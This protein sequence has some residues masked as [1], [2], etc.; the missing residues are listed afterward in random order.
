MAPWG[1]QRSLGKP[2]AS[3][4]SGLLG[5]SCV[6]KWKGW[7]RGS[8][9]GITVQ[10]QSCRRGFLQILA[11]ASVREGAAC[12]SLP[13]TYKH[14]TD[15]V[16]DSKPLTELLHWAR[17]VLDWGHPAETLFVY[18]VVV[19]LTLSLGT[20]SPSYTLSS[21]VTCSSPGWLG[22]VGSTSETWRR[23]RRNA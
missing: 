12:I 14:M 15:L 17:R 7:S 19:A 23:R 3:A 11:R 5:S 1:R 4:E 6:I 22:R 10:I 16:E 2:L 21:L 13:H 18:G 20:Y 8:A 9:L